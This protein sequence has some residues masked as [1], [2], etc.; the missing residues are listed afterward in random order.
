MTERF[1][2][3]FDYPNQIEKLNIIN[4]MFQLSC[5]R[6]KDDKDILRLYYQF[7]KKHRECLGIY[8]KQNDNNLDLWSMVEYFTNSDCIDDLETGGL[9]FLLLSIYEN[10]E[11]LLARLVERTIFLAIF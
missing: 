4:F 2:Q 5:D 10:D 3:Y 7:L 9:C 11:S 6:Q 8:L 1:F